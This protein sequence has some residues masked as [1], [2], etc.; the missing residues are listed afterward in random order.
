[1]RLRGRHNPIVRMIV[2]TVGTRWR[3]AL[4][5]ALAT[6]VVTLAPALP[7]QAHDSSTLPDAPYYRSTVTSITPVISGLT[8]TMD[9]AGESITLVNNTGSVVE[10][11][12]YSGEPYLRFT[13]AG[14]EEN[15]NSLSAFLNGS[16]VIEGLPQQMG[17]PQKPPAWRHVAD[18]PSFTWHDHRIHWMSQQRPPVV[19]ADP[20]H[21]HTVFDWTLPLTVGGAP[22]VVSGVLR[23]IGEPA[24]SGLQGSLYVVGGTL[25]VL[26]AWVVW[27]RVRRG[28]RA[29]AGEPVSA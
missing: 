2:T 1:M 21:P 22:V 12:G 14:V 8:I 27:L 13:S 17:A 10:V 15:T 6:A 26:V 19:A 11:P 9:K 28:L 16:L 25:L 23:W 3:R 4:A 5:G 18:L 29:K 20:G 7:A 24:F